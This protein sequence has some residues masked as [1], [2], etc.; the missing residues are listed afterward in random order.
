LLKKSGEG[1]GSGD[2]SLGLLET[3]SG[4]PLKI[5]EFRLDEWG[6]RR[7]EAAQKAILTIC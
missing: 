6:R 7:H 4:A 1:A 5:L 2:F 3:P